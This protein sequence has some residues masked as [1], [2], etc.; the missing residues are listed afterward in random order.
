MLHTI[1]NP[2]AHSGH[3]LSQKAEGALADWAPV[4]IT[5]AVLVGLYKLG[6]AELP[7]LEAAISYKLTSG[8]AA[9][10]NPVIQSSSPVSSGAPATGL[11]SDQVSQ[12]QSLLNLAQNL[13]SGSINSGT[14]PSSTANGGSGNT[15]STANGGD[16][17]AQFAANWAI[18][19]ACVRGW[20]AAN[21]GAV[22]STVAQVSAWALTTG[23]TTAR[24]AWAC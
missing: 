4:A 22:P 12:L 24:G 16:P 6:S 5:A 3:E 13:N 9:T 7:S 8:P 10:T 21:G 23:H 15:S 18:P 1:V 19:V 2:I 20:S 17:L 14:P 11:T